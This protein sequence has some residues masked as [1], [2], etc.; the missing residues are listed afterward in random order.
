VK[1][2]FVRALSELDVLVR[3]GANGLSRPTGS[4]MI[5]V[6]K[7]MSEMNAGS[8]NMV[9]ESVTARSASRVDTSSWSE[10]SADGEPVG[11]LE[12]SI[13]A[14]GVEDDMK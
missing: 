13:G 4:G 6:E 3:S 7:S 14:E 5:G 9:P 2:W 8:W 11:A 10:L 12:V 1:S